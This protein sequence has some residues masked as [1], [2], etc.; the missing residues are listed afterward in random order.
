MLCSVICSPLLDRMS[1]QLQFTVE[2]TAIIHVYYVCLGGI[3]FGSLYEF[4]CLDPQ[5]CRYSIY[6][7]TLQFATLTY[8]HPI[9][10]LNFQ[11]SCR[12]SVNFSCDILQ[13]APYHLI[14]FYLCVLRLFQQ[15]FSYIMATSFSDGGSRSTGENHRPWES[16]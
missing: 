14:L 11:K 7:T 1:I 16:N 15:H 10:Y 4:V 3:H 8:C 9:Q 5:I 12:L 13:T 6:T 2:N